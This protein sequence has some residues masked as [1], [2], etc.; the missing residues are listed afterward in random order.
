[1]K[2]LEYPFAGEELLRRKK[3]I[4]KELL[5]DGS[6]RIPKRIAILGG[7]TTNDIRLMLELF[8]LDYGIAPEFYESEYNQ[9]YEEAMFPGAELQEFAP[10]II[11][12]H[13]SYHNITAFPQLA[14]T[15]EQIEA[16]LQAEYGRYCGMWDALAQ[17]FGCIVIQN[18]FEYPHYRLLGNMDAS[19]R[20][21][22]VNFVTRLNCLFY[23]Y[24]GTHENFY[25][26][27]INYLSAVYGLDRWADSFSWH[28]Y[29]YC[30][31]VSAIPEFAFSLAK[32]IK[33]LYGKNKKGYVLDLDNTLWG[34]IV[35][36]DGPENIEVGQETS[37]GQ[38]YQEFQAYLKEQKQLGVLL[39]IDSKNEYENA[40]AGLEHPGGVLK[41]ED[42][43]AIRANWEPKDKNLTDI[44]AELSLLPESLVFVDDNPAERAIVS[45]QVPGVAA[46]EMGTVE[47]YIRVLDRSGFFEATGISADDLKRNAMYR[48]NAQR[49]AL[50]ASFADY[51]EY[52]RSLMMKAE[53]R[54]FAPAWLARIAQLTNKSNQF[55][56]TTKR[57]SQAE[58]AAVAA[59]PAYLTLYGKLEDRFGDNGVVSV[60]IGRQEGDVLFLDLWIMSCRVLKRDMEC[61]MM[62]ALAQRAGE[63][64]I[65][66]IYGFYYP[67]A[68][69]KMVRDFYGE[70]GFSRVS[71]DAA[72][73]TK[74]E[75]S[76]AVYR[77][78]NTVIQVEDER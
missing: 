70:R 11:Y 23:D 9:Y 3:R 29:K 2:C 67:T 56:L 13:T 61:A 37:M 28:M 48:E 52:L 12:L 58:I 19:D 62:D 47:N 64:G 32:I 55:N 57:Y 1:M 33:A 30:C 36:D 10:D 35:G 17:R 49:T 50:Q 15:P 18:N 26:H 38:V 65:R 4:K 74:W 27:D 20:H 34:G 66:T 42:F 59:D 31:N 77:P 40:V 75:L 73:N 69:N 39:N 63:R 44:A 25:I 5:A 72:G 6:V 54:P 45:A 16:M 46:P 14:D 53:I 60:V 24:A 22:K 68:K 71:Q 8:L 78:Q 43:I 41:K 21:G 51:G 7:S 76:L